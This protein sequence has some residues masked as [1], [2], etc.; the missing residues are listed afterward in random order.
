MVILG[1][2][3]CAIATSN[4]N[5][6]TAVNKGG[7]GESADTLPLHTDATQIRAWEEFELLQVSEKEVALKTANGYFVTAINGGGV[8]ESANKYPL[9][10][11]STHIDSWEIFNVCFLDNGKCA[12]ETPSGNYLTAVN[13][14]NMYE[15]HA[16]L[17]TNAKIVGKNERFKLIVLP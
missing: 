2:M 9:H 3:K 4:G 15:E 11:D 13:K 14:G 8:G 16:A 1:K 7:M 6:V 5:F 10:T 17:C 12:I